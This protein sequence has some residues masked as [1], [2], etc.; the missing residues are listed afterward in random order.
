MLTHTLLSWC[1]ATQTVCLD[2]GHAC[3]MRR[4]QHCSAPAISRPPLCLG[5]ICQYETSVWRDA[6][7]HDRHRHL[8]SVACFLFWPQRQ[9]IAGT[10]RRIEAQHRTRAAFCRYVVRTKQALRDTLC[11]ARFVRSWIEE[12]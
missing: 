7:G 11:C 12:H 10:V 2:A 3:A 5:A 9:K 8:S 6:R 4:K 1:A